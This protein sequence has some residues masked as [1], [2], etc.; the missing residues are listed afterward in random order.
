M[1]ALSDRLEWVR[2]YLIGALEDSGGLVA[3]DLALDQL[4]EA[5]MIADALPDLS[6]EALA[7]LNLPAAQPARKP[8]ERVAY[9]PGVTP[10][11]AHSP[12]PLYRSVE[13]IGVAGGATCQQGQPCEDPAACPDP[14]GCGVPR[15]PFFYA[16]FAPLIVGVTLSFGE[17]GS[18]IYRLSDGSTKGPFPITTDLPDLSEIVGEK[19]LIQNPDDPNQ[20]VIFDRLPVSL[21]S[22]AE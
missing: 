15:V 1:K 16:E 20:Y 13:P 11:P 4:L 6:A 9:V 10:E 17:G 21:P 18:I 14:A 12:P 22:K 8:P 2:L 7:P 19:V 3:R 5:L